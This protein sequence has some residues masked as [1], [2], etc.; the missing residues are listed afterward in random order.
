MNREYKRIVEQQKAPEELIEKTRK[1]MKQLQRK[2]KMKR[3]TVVLASAACL[4]IVCIAGIQMANRSSAGI[5]EKLEA[6]EIK[7]EEFET[8]FLLGKG[9]LKEEKNYESAFHVMK[10]KNIEEVPEKVWRLKEQEIRGKQIRF[11]YYEKEGTYCA[12]CKTDNVYV[13]ITGENVTEK[14]MKKFLE[15]NL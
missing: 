15:K 13:Y 4:G 1:K 11:G 3:Y 5:Y 2:K 8:G 10:Y 9:F 6:E 12:L 7:E 14:E